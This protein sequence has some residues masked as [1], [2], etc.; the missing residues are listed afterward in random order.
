MVEENDETKPADTGEPAPAGDVDQDSDTG[1]DGGYDDSGDKSNEPA[2]EESF[3]EEPG[4]SS[5][6]IP[7]ERFED[8]EKQEEENGLNSSPNKK[9]A[10]EEQKMNPKFK[11]LQETGR[12]GEIGK[13]EIMVGAV[14]VVLAV[15]G[16][17][18]ALVVT[19]GDDTPATIEARVIRP[20]GNPTSSPTNPPVAATVLI[21]IVVQALENSSSVSAIADPSSLPRN[22][23]FYD[24]LADQETASAP[25]RAMSWLLATPYNQYDKDVMDDF[26]IR[27][28]L[29]SIYYQLGGASW[30]RS[31]NW[32][33]SESICNWEGVDCEIGGS[34]IS[35][36]ILD[37][38]NLNGTIPR[39]IAL[40]QGIKKIWLSN[41]NLKG[42]I[43]GDAF[44]E[45]S[46]L[47]V[48]YLNGN[49][50]TGMVPSSLNPNQNLNTLYV[51]G[52]NL[53]G[54]WPF[55]PT[56]FGGAKVIQSFGLDCLED[57]VG[58]F[59][60]IGCCDDFACY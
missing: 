35:D 52:N 33:S 59:C 20:T 57:G 36:L 51:Q 13:K 14:F 31:D 38:M 49:Q 56:I 19:S 44:G 3:P 6:S 32:L 9:A 54:R 2:H 15:I 18:V 5:K 22:S 1:S 25:Q 21:D 48:L 23:A 42:E 24:G 41:N 29:A 17:I 16:V 55:C 11:D 8:E 10:K 58:V 7:K 43:P 28:A 26:V 47:A 37:R 12:W 46:N 30:T 34:E 50:L 45:L 4:V 27:F 60:Q 39:E 53:S 40:L